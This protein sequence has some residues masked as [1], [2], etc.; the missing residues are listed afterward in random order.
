VATSTSPILLLPAGSAFDIAVTAVIV[1]ESTIVCCW[2]DGF[3]LVDKATSKFEIFVT[4][5]S[6]DDKEVLP[7]S[8]FSPVAAPLGRAEE[9]TTTAPVLTAVILPSI[10]MCSPYPV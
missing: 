10:L 1:P 7:V 8:C 5:V 2:S 4:F 6:I 9:E 3:V